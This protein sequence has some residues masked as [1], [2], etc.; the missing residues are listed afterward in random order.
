MASDKNIVEKHEE[1]VYKTDF[2]V[3]HL[4]RRSWNGNIPSIFSGKSLKIHDMYVL[5]E[6]MRLV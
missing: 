3:W 6:K 2:T 4:S 1:I 5:R